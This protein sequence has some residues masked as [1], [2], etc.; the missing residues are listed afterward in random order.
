VKHP[1]NYEDV[2]RRHAIPEVLFAP[3]IRLVLGISEVEAESRA[4]TG[5]FGPH[6][7]VG[8]RVGVLRRDFL[9][10]L[11]ELGEVKDESGRELLKP[12]LRAVRPEAPDER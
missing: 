11:A 6:F 9:D 5:D 7:Y 8:G 12:R 4:S 3:D 1:S 10:S 2:L